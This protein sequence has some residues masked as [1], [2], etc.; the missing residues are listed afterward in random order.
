MGVERAV[1]RL[2]AYPARPGGVPAAV[3]EAG[4]NGRT[5][6]GPRVCRLGQRNGGF[7]IHLIIGRVP[8][9]DRRPVSRGSRGRAP[10]GGA[11]AY[12]YRGTAPLA[13]KAATD[14]R[15]A[16][17]LMTRAA[18]PGAVPD[19]G[20]RVVAVV[21]SYNRRE[22]LGRTLS[23]IVAGSA[24]PAVIVVVDNASKD[25]S[26]A[27]VRGFESEVPIDLV[28]LPANVGG[29]GGFTVGIERA[30]LDH[31]ADLVWVMDD[32][33][34]PQGETLAEAVR[35]WEGYAAG[36]E[37]RPTVLASRVLWSDGREHPMNSMRER[38][39]A[40]RAQRERA[41]RVGGRPIRLASFVSAFLAGDAVRELGLPIADYFLWADDF[42]F[43]TR[44]T[45]FNDAVQIPSSLVVHHTK[46]FGTTDVDPGPRFY[47]E[48]RNRLWTYLRSQSLAPWERL[49][50]T[51]VTLRI[52]AR[53]F[54]RSTDRGV[55]L[56]CLRRGL[57]DGIRAPR[58]N[59]E[60]L[61]GVYPLRDVP[62][63]PRTA[64]SRDGE[65]GGEPFSLLMPLSDGDTPERFRRAVDSGT[66][67][68][69]RPPAE[70]V[71]VR[72][73]PVQAGLQA[74]LDAVAERLPLPV[75]VIALPDNGGLTAA[76]G[77]G[78]DACAHDIVARADADDVSLP[79]RFAVQIPVVE[80]G[81]VLVG[82][83]MEEIGED[84]GGAARRPGRADRT[85]GDP[86]HRPFLQPR[87]PSDGRLPP[88]RGRGR[89]RL[90]AGAGGGGLLAVRQAARGRGRGA[91]RP[92]DARALPGER[93]RLC[94]PRRP[95]GTPRRPRRPGPVAG[96]GVP[97][98]CSVAA[99]RGRQGPLPL[100]AHLG[101]GPV[102][103]PDGRPPSVSVPRMGHPGGLAAERVPAS[104]GTTGS[105]GIVER[106]PSSRP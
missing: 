56:D 51:A 66:I 40:S 90:P 92:R 75:T 47:Y 10:L 26:A 83:A 35:A 3:T 7:P 95:D 49:A 61:A 97:E 78:L 2:V 4:F 27:F 102:V 65:S 29:A 88:V 76:L 33:T 100:P 16:R 15:T 39:G 89:G 71:I 44:L 42:E 18:A 30:V 19:A 6:P 68:Q 91:Q 36:V 11:A 64:P 60:V 12:Q 58:G 85:P 84:E 31:G 93:R 70:L 8:A 13:P 41:R 81:A 48:V 20:T 77:H 9:E 46:K 101:A 23:G 80:R 99:E 72:D 37:Q 57:R 79:E 105:R 21:V 62:S 43:T 1:H 5:S 59:A 74:E 54:A 32:D 67:E 17:P 94:A 24:R 50:Y 104:R 103:S 63:L 53:T 55:L 82:S 106:P 69:E 96:L 28:E 45:R 98:R 38:L 86:A 52:W 87:E 73:G 14:P 34:E 22:L 25:G